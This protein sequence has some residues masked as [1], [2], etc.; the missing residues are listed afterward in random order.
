ML[1]LMT[2]ELVGRWEERGNPLTAVGTEERGGN[3]LC[4]NQGEAS[5]GE[6]RKVGLV[7]LAVWKHEEGHSFEVLCIKIYTEP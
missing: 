3:A 4:Q 6:R 2:G 7:I 1:C 5:C